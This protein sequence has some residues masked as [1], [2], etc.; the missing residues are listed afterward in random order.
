MIGPILCIYFMTRHVQPKF[1][2]EGAAV[3]YGRDHAWRELR[4][5]RTLDDVLKD[6]PDGVQV[7]MV[8]KGNQNVVPA[9]D[10]GLGVR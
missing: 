2:A 3:S 6:L 10:I 1:P 5:G 7:T 8:R 4:A 9:G